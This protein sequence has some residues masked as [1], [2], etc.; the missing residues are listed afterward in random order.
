VATGV[1]TRVSIN[2]RHSLEECM[3]GE[4]HPSRFSSRE[5]LPIRSFDRLLFAGGSDGGIRSSGRLI[6]G[7]REDAGG[8]AGRE[9]EGARPLAARE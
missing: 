8:A 2:R 9:F 4:R 5:E 1:I 6:L 3:E 7:Q